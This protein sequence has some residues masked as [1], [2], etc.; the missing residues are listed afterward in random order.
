[1]NFSVNIYSEKNNEIERFLKDYYSSEEI[2]INNKLYW[3][4][5]FSSPF[6]LIDIISVYIDNKEKYN[7]N[8]WISLDTNVYICVT[9]N[10]INHLIKYIYERFPN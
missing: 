1:M 2:T 9:E 7:I 3:N 8:I 4:K 6:D 5:I 10:N